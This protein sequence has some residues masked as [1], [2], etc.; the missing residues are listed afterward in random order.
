MSDIESTL[1]A[2]LRADAPVTAITSRVAT[3]TPPALEQPWVRLTLLDDPPHR[4][5]RAL[6]LFHAHVQL[7]CYGGNGDQAQ[8]EARALSHAVRVAVHALPATALDGIVVSAV[9]GL[10][11]RRLPDDELQPARE[12]Y[13]VTAT[14]TYH[15][16]A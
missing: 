6:H 11:R 12:R 16:A 4:S 13:I 14:V 1:I 7:D 3:R 9:T 15:F 2:H 8:L 10:G 5:S